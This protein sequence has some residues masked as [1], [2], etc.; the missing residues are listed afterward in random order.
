MVNES[1]ASLMF[2][3]NLSVVNSTFMNASKIQHSYHIL[4]YHLIKEAQAKN[5][6]KFVQMNGNVNTDNTEI[7]LLI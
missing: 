3:E 7:Y 6:I 5:I 1:D 4:N 2:G